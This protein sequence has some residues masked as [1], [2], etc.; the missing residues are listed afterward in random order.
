MNS[1]QPLSVSTP[2]LPCS[3]QGVQTI[4]FES[5]VYQVTCVVLVRLVSLA[6]GPYTDARFH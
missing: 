5:L 4:Q 6:L 2:R 1:R 3:C